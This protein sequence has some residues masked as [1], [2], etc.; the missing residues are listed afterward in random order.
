MDKSNVEAALEA[1][2]ALG[3]VTKTEAGREYAVLPEGARLQ[4]LDELREFPVRAKGNVQVSELDSFIRYVKA[5][6][7]KTRIFA[8][9]DKESGRASFNA[10]L[11]Y[12]EAQEGKPGWC[13]H[14]LTLS[15]ALSVEWQRWL[16]A[17]RAHM[18][19]EQFAEFV[20]DNSGDVV[21]PSG[22]QML[23]IAK[24]LEAKTSVEFKS[25]V[26]LENGDHQ[27]RYASQTTGR[28]GGNGELEIPAL[29]ALGLV[30]FDGGPGYKVSAKLRY[31]IT[32]GRLVLWFDLINPHKVVDAACKEILATIKTETEIEAFIGSLRP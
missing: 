22:A 23:E 6:G 13:E 24:T 12:H 20:E 14:K 28:A 1:G 27:L 29:F 9:I 25:G 19:Q 2:M 18:N 32:D 31:R 11:D 7:G 17:N 30:I 3:G 4:V 15:P 8:S 21:E 16:A 5:F 10:I 26:R